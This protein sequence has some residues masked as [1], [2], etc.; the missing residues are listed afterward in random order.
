MFVKDTTQDNREMN[1]LLSKVNRN[2]ESEQ[3][4][5]GNYNFQSERIDFI[6]IKD[7]YRYVD[8]EEMEQSQPDFNLFN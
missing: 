1:K 3:S 5:N 2:N 6:D 4:N 7:N 8:G